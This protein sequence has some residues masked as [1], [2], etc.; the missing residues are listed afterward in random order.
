MDA[1]R[2]LPLRERSPVP[3]PSW[4]RCG[5]A[6]EMFVSA[7]RNRGLQEHQLVRRM[8]AAADPMQ[9]WT[10]RCRHIER[11]PSDVREPGVRMVREA[12]AESGE[13]FGAVTRGSPA[14]GPWAWDLAQLGHA[15]GGWPAD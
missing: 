7:F 2:H 11:Y 13:R 5:L 9:T 4:G 8:R 10:L 3:S 6:L 14:A 12:I 1:W 15:G